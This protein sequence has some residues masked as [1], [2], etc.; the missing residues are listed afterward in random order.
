MPTTSAVNQNNNNIEEI[1]SYWRGR[2]YL[3]GDDDRQKAWLRSSQ[4]LGRTINATCANSI[5]QWISGEFSPQDVLWDPPVPSYHNS[6][7]KSKTNVA[8]DLILWQ[9]EGTLV[10]C[11]D[12][13]GLL[14]CNLVR[15]IGL[16]I[17][18]WSSTSCSRKIRELQFETFRRFSFVLWSLWPAEQIQ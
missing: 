3:Q 17:D 8:F 10:I 4:S 18:I 2:R 15:G 7:Q 12:R 5:T 9:K 1:D 14:S 16:F 11:N 13:Y 6:S